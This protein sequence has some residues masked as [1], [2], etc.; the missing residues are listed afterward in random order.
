[1]N[2]T[3]GQGSLERLRKHTD[4]VSINPRFALKI[5]KLKTRTSIFRSVSFLGQSLEMHCVT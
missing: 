4:D 3:F 2:K 1:M 5:L